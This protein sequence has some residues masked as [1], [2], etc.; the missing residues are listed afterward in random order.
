MKKSSEEK[1]QF[2]DCEQST[3]YIPNMEA[4]VAENMSET[5]FHVRK[6]CSCF[7]LGIRTTTA[8]FDILELDVTLI[9]VTILFTEIP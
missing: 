2:L 5:F 1:L 9:S 4:N 6:V 3:Y 8:E 7:L